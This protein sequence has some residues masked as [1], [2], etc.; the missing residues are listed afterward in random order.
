MAVPNSNFDQI[1]AITNDYFMPT[2]PDLV[3]DANPVLNELHKNGRIASSGDAIAQPLMYQFSQDGAYFDYQKGS[4]AAEDQV[5]QANWPWKLYRQRV[6]MSVPEINRNK[7]PEGVFNLLKTKMKGAATA[8]R[9]AMANDMYT[10]A[11]GDAV[12]G[13]NSLPN[14][15]GDGAF[16]ASPTTSGGIDKATASNAF[17][18]GAADD[19]VANTLG[20]TDEMNILWSSLQDGNIHPNMIISHPTPQRVHFEEASKGAQSLKRYVN[21][22][23]IATG[24]DEYSYMGQRWVLDNHLNAAGTTGSADLFML[25]TEFISMVSH[26]DENF[27]WSGFQTPDDQNVRIGWIYWMGNLTSSDPSRS[28][29]LYT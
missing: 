14:I 8:I 7:S 15:L 25:N 6:V 12:A 4:T 13:L 24:Y 29:M 9:E 28:G 23:G 2:L 11:N 27:R 18:Q 17:F 5:T 16:P 22:T 20:S 10:E 21:T 26:R 3:F 1:S 19:I